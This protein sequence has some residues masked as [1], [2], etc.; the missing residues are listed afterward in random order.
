MLHKSSAKAIPAGNSGIGVMA[1]TREAKR[2][3][4][5]SVF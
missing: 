3:N 5:F 1:I 2:F 4:L